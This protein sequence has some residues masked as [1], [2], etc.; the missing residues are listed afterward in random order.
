MKHFYC[1]ASLFI[2]SVISVCYKFSDLSKFLRQ[3]LEYLSL[4]SGELRFKKMVHLEYTKTPTQPNQTKPNQTKPN[5]Q[6][7]DHAYP[8]ATSTPWFL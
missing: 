2:S 3:T 5:N 1:T 8:F 7:K 6:Q 4:V